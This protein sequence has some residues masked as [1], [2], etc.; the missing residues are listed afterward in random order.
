M[1]QSNRLLGVIGAEGK[2]HFTPGRSCGSVRSLLAWDSKISEANSA[3]EES[4]PWRKM[5]ERVCAESGGT[6]WIASVDGMFC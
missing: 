6:S 3:A 5:M 4:R 2:T 1:S